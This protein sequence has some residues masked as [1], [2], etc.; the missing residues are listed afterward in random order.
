[1]TAPISHP[2][3]LVDFDLFQVWL[4]ADPLTN[5]FDPF[6]FQHR[7]AAYRQMIDVTNR[8][9]RFGP[10][11]RRNPLWG[12]MFQHQWQFRT[13]RLGTHSR[14]DDRIDPDATWGYG[15][16][17]LSVARCGPVSCRGSGSSTSRSDG[18]PRSPP[19]PRTSA[20][21]PTVGRPSASSSAN[22]AR[23]R[24]SS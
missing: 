3:E 6:S 12:L 13:G 16:Y 11:N 7:M 17:T 9:G 19:S 20:G 21:S 1:M 23:A 4:A 10:D 2:A 8:G 14:A 24:R 22:T 18:R 5:R 15:N